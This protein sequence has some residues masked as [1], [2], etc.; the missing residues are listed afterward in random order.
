MAKMVFVQWSQQV[1]QPRPR[2]IGLAWSG[3][4][5]QASR[6]PWHCFITKLSR[7]DAAV[8]IPRYTVYLF[9]V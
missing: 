4:Y 5:W 7:R 1:V 8:L 6:L 9:W 3:L 2:G